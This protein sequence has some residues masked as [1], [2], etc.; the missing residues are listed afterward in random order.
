MNK[1][2]ITINDETKKFSNYES[3]LEFLG[4][5]KPFSIT[6][7][8]IGG[9]EL[10]RD[11]TNEWATISNIEQLKDLAREHSFNYDKSET[12]IRKLLKII[13]PQWRDHWDGGGGSGWCEEN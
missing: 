12:D 4:T 3:A 10:L 8:Y 13:E 9:Y 11:G 1:I 7:Y 2:E 6:F 5:V